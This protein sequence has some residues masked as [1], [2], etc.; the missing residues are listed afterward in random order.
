MAFCY[1]VLINIFLAT[2]AIRRK[3]ASSLYHRL[4]YEVL[5]PSQVPAYIHVVALI[6]A[7][8][9]S[10]QFMSILSMDLSTM[11]S[12][13]SLSPL[14]Y[15]IYPFFILTEYHAPYY[16]TTL[17][18]IKWDVPRLILLLVSNGLVLTFNP[19]VGM[20]QLIFALFWIFT[21]T[22]NQFLK[23]KLKEDSK[24]NHHTITT[25]IYV[26]SLGWF[27]L[28]ALIFDI[29]VLYQNPPDPIIIGFILVGAIIELF[30]VI[31]YSIHW[32]KLNESSRIS[33]EKQIEV[34]FTVI[35][36][37]IVFRP[38]LHIINYIGMTMCLICYF[39]YEYIEKK[40]I[41]SEETIV[42]ENEDID[43]EI[44]EKTEDQIYVI[45]DKNETEEQ[46][47]LESV[48]R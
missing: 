27:L 37:L 9:F 18:M 28:L 36:S 38:Q 47:E 30:V 48:K 43:E 33:Y 31:F 4:E 32:V 35:F 25:Y 26:E 39:A 44:K 11:Q 29:P 10:L 13:F 20:T 15:T 17:Q 42:A 7:I 1:S 5:T 21:Y 3:F 22:L 24:L 41:K 23:I 19:N 14:F 46:I 16:R 40:R 34:A 12:L 45:E 8:A 6:N 2:T